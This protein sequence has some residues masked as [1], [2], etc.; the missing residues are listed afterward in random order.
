MSETS[1]ELEILD[2]ADEFIA[3]ANRL[4][5]ENRKD[6]GYIST[7]LRYAAARFSAHE[8]SYKSADLAADRD[9]AQTW[10]VEQF[11]RMLGENLDQ[12]IE[13]MQQQQ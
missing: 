6:L 3:V 4:L 11:N 10:Y 8:A 1:M 13:A 12:R 5:E 2:M 9:K 7:A